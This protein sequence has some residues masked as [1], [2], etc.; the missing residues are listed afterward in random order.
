MCPQARYVLSQG[1]ILSEDVVFKKLE[2]EPEGPMECE[3]K[4]VSLF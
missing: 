4:I 2:V 3:P 1:K